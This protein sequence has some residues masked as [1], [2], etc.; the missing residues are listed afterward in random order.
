MNT[1]EE[2]LNRLWK[3]LNIRSDRG[4]TVNSD[5][6]NEVIYPAMEEYAKEQEKVKDE[7]RFCQMFQGGV[8][9]E[10]RNF[11]LLKEGTGLLLIN[12]FKKEKADRDAEFLRDTLSEIQ[13]LIK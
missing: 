1:K 11:P 6:V 12:P 10:V 3:E 7:G 2:I 8:V 4:V 5:F 9:I 13:D